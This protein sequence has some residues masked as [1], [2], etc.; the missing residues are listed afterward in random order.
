MADSLPDAT[1]TRMI[2]ATREDYQLI[3]RHTLQAFDG[4]G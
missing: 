3:A 2:D 1:F 4:Y